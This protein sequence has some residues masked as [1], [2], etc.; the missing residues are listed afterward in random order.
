MSWTV[1]VASE[2]DRAILGAFRC[3]TGA[4]CPTCSPEG[5]NIHEREIE[6]YLHR[7]A[8]DEAVHRRPYT[9]HTLLLLEDPSDA[10]AGVVAYERTELKVKGEEVDAVS[11]VAAAV[12][13]DLRGT[14]AN[15][16]RL[17]SHLIAA[18][19]RGLAE[20]PPLVIGRVAVCNQRSRGLLRRHAIDRELAQTDP[21]YLDI[22]GATEDVLATLPPPL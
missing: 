20:V 4:D 17:S 2:P 6:E 15:G 16:V 19:V 5:G 9:G 13:R 11:L 18:G 3:D 8:L 1:R 10:L 14:V 7:L 12:R 22:A 21:G